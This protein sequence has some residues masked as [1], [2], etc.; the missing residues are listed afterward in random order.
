MLN[1]KSKIRIFNEQTYLSKIIIEA[2]LIHEQCAR[3]QLVSR[4]LL[5][6]F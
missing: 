6:I 4:E 3:F 2:P 5:N 1:Q